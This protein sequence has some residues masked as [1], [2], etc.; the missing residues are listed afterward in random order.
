MA[1]SSGRDDPALSEQLFARS[2]GF[3]FF[4]AVR[5]FHWMAIESARLDSSP[6]RKP[7]GYDVV[8]Q[9][10]QVRFRALASHS[11]PA[12]CISE[13]RRAGSDAGPGP[14]Q[15]VTAFF[16]LTG[17]QGA[18]PRHY[19]TT[20][21]E[22][23]RAK[24]FSLR[25]FFDTIHHRM[26]SLYYRAWQKYRFAFAYEQEAAGGSEE[27]DLF[28]AG[29]YSIIGMG[30]GGLRGRMA[31]DDEALLYYAGHL[32]HWPRSASALEGMLADYFELPVAIGQ[33]QGQ[34]LYLSAEDQSSLPSPRW[35][36]GLNSQLGVDVIVGER[37]WNVESKF[38]VK[39]GPLNYSQFVRLMPCGDTLR[40]LCE[41]AW[42]YVG[43]HLEFDVQLI[44]KAKEVPWCRLGGDG[45]DPARLGWNTWVRSGEFQDDV[46]DAI[47]SL[48]M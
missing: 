35:P 31:V 41:M 27:E 3:E 42:F 38:R 6:P 37:V 47:F 19:T 46:S 8:P 40:P 12:G 17:P 33:F 5:L 45:A 14:A 28:T 30:T 1:F 2:H 10:E 21:I 26:L 24:D 22:R 36:G 44:L 13:I 34:W 7:V 16:G 32:S 48:E 23:I 4:Q 43:A 11:F 20:M 29:L 39:V 25:D 15:M 18:L 9:Q